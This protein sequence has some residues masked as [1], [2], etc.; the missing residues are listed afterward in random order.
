MTG[1]LNAL[2][3]QVSV[4]HVIKIQGVGANCRKVHAPRLVPTGQDVINS[5]LY[6]RVLGEYNVPQTAHDRS[7]PG[8]YYVPYNLLK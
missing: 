5:A 8:E 3:K 6:V 1:K 7:L 4:A 2:K